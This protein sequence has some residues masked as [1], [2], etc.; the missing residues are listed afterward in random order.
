[1]SEYTPA[2]RIILPMSF[3]T[4]THL[5]LACSC[6]TP[7]TGWRTYFQA[8]A[9]PHPDE[10]RR[11]TSTSTPL[12]LSHCG[13]ISGINIHGIA[14]LH[15]TVLDPSTRGALIAIRVNAFE[16]S[17]PVSSLLKHGILRLRGPA[18]TSH[19]HHSEI[20][21]ITFQVVGLLSYSQI[22]FL[23]PSFNG[24]GRAFNAY[25][26]GSDWI[27]V[28]LDYDVHLDGDD[29]KNERK[30]KVV[31]YPSI[32]RFPTPRTLLDYD[33]YFGRICLRSAITECNVIEIFDLS[34]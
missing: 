9:L 2:E 28:A 5:F 6:Y 8:F 21:T 7:F 11:L 34:V 15:D 30:A 24:V 17:C 27:V 25:K 1:M 13:V 10:C 26:K 23:R 31:E 12:S 32:L 3:S 18:H 14:V 4:S 29:N 20:G 16:S 33:P 19:D 22:P